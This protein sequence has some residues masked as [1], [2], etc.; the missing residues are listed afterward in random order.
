M[1]KHGELIKTGLAAAPPTPLKVTCNT[2]SFVAGISAY[3]FGD[4]L[5]AVSFSSNTSHFLN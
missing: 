2:P 4:L 1:P 3:G 5:F